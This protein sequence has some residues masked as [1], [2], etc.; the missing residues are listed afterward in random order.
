MI[1]LTNLNKRQYEAVTSSAKH[2]R[3]ISGAGSGKTR[4]LTTRIA[5]LIEDLC[6]DPSQILAITFTNKAAKEMNKRLNVMIG[7]EMVKKATIS[8]IHSLCVKILR[9][10]CGEFHYPENFGILTPDGQKI[11]LDLAYEKYGINKY[12]ITYAQAK[13]KI[14]KC[15]LNKITY[16]KLDYTMKMIYDFYIKYQDKNFLLDFDD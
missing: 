14:S 6:V 16:E 4:V 1:D 3:V 2:T 11:I 12:Q 7:C 5:Y 15:K 10:T 13:N 8:T 9:Q